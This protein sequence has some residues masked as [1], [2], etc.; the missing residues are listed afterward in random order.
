MPLRGYPYD[1]SKLAPTA[2][3]Q[4][5]LLAD[6]LETGDPAFIAH[7]L[8][9]IGR[10]TAKEHLTDQLR[11]ADIAAMPLPVLLRLVRALGLAVTART[12]NTGVAANDPG[13][14][15]PSKEHHLSAQAG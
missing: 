12:G 6:A 14:P 11:P 13:D 15:G 2:E 4:A 1:A 5:D 7:A 8:R 3:T 9:C 10:V